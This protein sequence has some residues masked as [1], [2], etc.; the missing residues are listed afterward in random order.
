MKTTYSI[1]TSDDWYCLYCGTLG[2]CI[3]RLFYHVKNCDYRKI[4]EYCLFKVKHPERL[5]L[6]WWMWGDCYLLNEDGEIDDENDEILT[7]WK[8]IKLKKSDLEFIKKHLSY[9]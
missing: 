1:G 6:D 3:D 7:N 8:L 4:T 2:Q 9:N 5:T